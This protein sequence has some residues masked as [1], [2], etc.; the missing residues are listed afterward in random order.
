MTHFKF[1]K[2]RAAKEPVDDRARVT[3]LLKEMRIVFEG[4]LEL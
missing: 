2:E 3:K 1:F 4:V